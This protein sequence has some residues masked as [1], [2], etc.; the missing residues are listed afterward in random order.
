M[1]KE[2]SIADNVLGERIKELE[3]LSAELLEALK[4]WQ[5]SHCNCSRCL[6]TRVLIAKA[7]KEVNQ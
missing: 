2:L 3:A 1:T 6:I 5:Q 7:G 4:R